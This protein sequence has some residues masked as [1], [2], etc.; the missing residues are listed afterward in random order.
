MTIEDVGANP[1]RLAEAIHL[2]LGG[3]SGSIPIADVAAALDIVEIRVERLTTFEG[4][5]VTTP[6]RGSG[7]IL[8]NQQSSSRRRRFT[9]AHE[10]L[11]FLNPYHEQTSVNGFWCSQKDM[12]EREAKSRDRH[13][14]QEAEANAFA[15]E[16]LVPRKRL[17]TYL[18]GD[19]DLAAV[20]SISED[21]DVS[22]E[23]AARHY[24]SCHDETIA[25][26]FARDGRFLYYASAPGFPGLSLR[27]GIPLPGLRPGNASNGISEIH[28][29][30]AEDWLAR[31]YG[32]SLVT[33][34]L[35]QQNGYSTT[36]LR[37]VSKPDDDDGIDDVYER[38]SGAGRE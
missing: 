12:T 27:S 29:A 1:G 4:A 31:P 23:A 26:V 11:H 21:F 24:V 22:R 28:E 19:P 32:I 37:I 36:L 35:H 33:H 7:S 25:A 10:L 30:E 5:L 34:T 13:I 15:I 8:V 2:Q 16:L 17:L 6:E 18:G 14:R 9:I 38:F 3:W 20:L